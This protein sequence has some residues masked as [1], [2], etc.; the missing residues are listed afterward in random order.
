MRENDIY[1]QWQ[2]DRTLLLS[3]R[4]RAVAKM[5]AE[6]LSLEVIARTI[7]P[8]THKTEV[9]KVLHGACLKLKCEPENLGDHF[10]QDEPGARS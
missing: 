8:P 9:K 3:K 4:E 2:G 7:D 1:D 5:T 10:A 6:G